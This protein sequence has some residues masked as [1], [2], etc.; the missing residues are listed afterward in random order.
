MRN[1]ITAL[2]MTISF[3]FAFA[4]PTKNEMRDMGKAFKK[5]NATIRDSSQNQNNAA[6][7]NQ[8]GQLLSAV[9]DVMPSTISELPPAQQAEAFA[10]YQEM[11]NQEIT[12]AGQLEQAFLNND[13]S[14]AKQIFEEMSDLMDQGHDRFEPQ[15]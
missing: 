10:T 7:A 1:F 15:E 8:I 14:L 11:I 5:I 12:L 4:G 13:N 2:L 3:S 6:L 9:V